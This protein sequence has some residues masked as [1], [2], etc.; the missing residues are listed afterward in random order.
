[1]VKNDV[2]E[3]ERF[4]R[5]EFKRL[6]INPYFRVVIGFIIGEVFSLAGIVIARAGFSSL[7][8]FSLGIG[9]LMMFYSIYYLSRLP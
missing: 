3:R 8:F 9:S 2:K 7:G 1:M 4:F 6:P 5:S